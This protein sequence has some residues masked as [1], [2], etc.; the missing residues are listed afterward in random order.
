MLTFNSDILE[1]S[2]INYL[3]NKQLNYSHAF[4]FL[5]KKIEESSDNNLEV[6]LCD[7][8]NLTQVEYRSVIYEVTSFHKIIKT[9]IK[10]KEK[11][12][13]D[14]QKEFK[15]LNSNDKKSK[16]DI[17]K[18]FKLNKS[19]TFLNNSIKND[20]VFGGRK[21]LQEITRL[22]NKLNN[23][24]DN[25]NLEEL[26]DRLEKAK[27]VYQNFR[28]KS[29]LNIGEANTKGNRFFNFSRLDEGIIM[30][31][32]NRKTKIEIK[33]RLKNKSLLT[34]LKNLANEKLIPL[35]VSFT[36]DNLSI[37]Y[38]EKIV[39]GYSLNEIE[40]RKEVSNIKALKLDKEAETM[41]IKDVYIKYHKELESRM[42]V[43]KKVNRCISID[44]NP[45]HIG[46]SIIDKLSD[47]KHD[48]QIIDKGCYDLTK[49]TKKLTR[50]ATTEE[51]KYNKNKRKYELDHIMKDLFKKAIHYGCSLFVM[52][53]LEFKSNVEKGKEFNRLVKNIWCR[54]QIEEQINKRCSINGIK[55][56][57]VFPCY[58]SFI[59]NMM[60][61]YFDPINSSIEIGRRGLYKYIKNLTGYPM[62]DDTIM[63]TVET[64]ILKNGED[65]SKIKGV[66]MNWVALYNL[67]KTYKY[68][69][70]LSNNK[71]RF[72]MM[73]KKSKINIVF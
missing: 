43:G 17:R 11:I 30:Y 60:Y 42:L 32:P 35:T 54:T 57:K 68:R 18:I 2:D 16:K 52:E 20:V 4:R 45:S 14:K 53:D 50:T 65:V 38:D 24:S 72:S 48:I 33:F 64:I 34:K 6:Y 10:N 29:C 67:L 12:I 49:L 69:G 37:S 71:G 44:M 47:T 41:M 27:R 8:F 31:N 7:R 55:L 51:R 59:G 39:N 28:I 46:Y 9:S 15:I 3:I 23:L 66:K 5:Y 26:N 25:D 21:N 63:N 62:I 56:E 40:R 73:N 19:I 22:N 61:N 13:T 1:C 36:K 58:S 70:G